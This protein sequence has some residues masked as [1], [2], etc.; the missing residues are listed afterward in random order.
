VQNVNAFG[1][2]LCDWLRR[3]KGAAT[4]N[5]A[6]YIGWFSTLYRFLGFSPEPTA[7]L[8]LAVRL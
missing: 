3:F 1:S 5:L 4:K 7:L 2:R 6:N 8:A